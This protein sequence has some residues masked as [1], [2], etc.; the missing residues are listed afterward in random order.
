[1]K[2]IQTIDD[3]MAWAREINSGISLARKCDMQDIYAHSKQSDINKLFIDSN[4]DRK[5]VLCSVYNVMAYDEVER[6]LKVLAKHKTKELIEAGHEELNKEWFEIR[7]GQAA[8]LEA[9]RHIY[10][11]I[12][13][14][15]KTNARLKAKLNSMSAFVDE[16]I[17]KIKEYKSKALKFDRLK[18]LLS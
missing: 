10:K 13:E 5:L 17:I 3:F 9:K 2:T 7:K 8:L 6:L 14:L 4:T 11:K 1:M 15:E 16:S 12:N 18:K